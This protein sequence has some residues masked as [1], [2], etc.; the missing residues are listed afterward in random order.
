[1]NNSTLIL[2]GQSIIKTTGYSTISSEIKS[3]KNILDFKRLMELK[4]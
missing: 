1:M 2:K 4:N 3:S